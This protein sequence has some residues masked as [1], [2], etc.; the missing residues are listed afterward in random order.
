MSDPILD[1]IWRV[2]EALIK[3]YGGLD[4]YLEYVK[5]LDQARRQKTQRI[6]RKKGKGARKG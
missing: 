3:E 2:R 6:K 1:E 5:K 4:G